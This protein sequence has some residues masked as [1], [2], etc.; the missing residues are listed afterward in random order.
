L[1]QFITGVGQLA[2]SI[3]TLVGRITRMFIEAI[4]SL[5]KAL[6]GKYNI[7]VLRWLTK[8]TSQQVWFTGVQ[9]IPLIMGIATVFSISLLILGYQNLRAVGAEA[10][11]GQIVRVGVINGLGPLLVSLIV[12][13]RSGTA[14]TAD[15]ASQVIRGELDVMKMHGIS[16]SI[17]LVVPRLLGV[18]IS[19]VVLTM[20]FIVTIYS[21][22]VVFTPILNLQVMEILHVTIE[23][24]VPMD[25]LVLS[26]K[27]SVFGLLIPLITVHKGLNVKRDIR[28]LPRV[29]S[30]A[31]V[32]CIVSVFVLDVLLSFL[33][34]V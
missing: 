31:V 22:F 9:V 14:I 27:S 15:V 13:A 2:L 16:A 17:M 26:I 10:H 1:V 12:I 25:F 7:S 19:N 18:W 6:S 28:D 29:S 8:L 32:T 11:F 5:G 34:L 30:Q 20:M 23:A 21:G 4:L 24:L 33:V 3:P